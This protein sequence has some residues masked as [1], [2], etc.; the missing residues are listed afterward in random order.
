MFQ[1]IYYSFNT[2]YR[3]NLFVTDADSYVYIVMLKTNLP[4]SLLEAMDR[5]AAETW[6]KVFRALPEEET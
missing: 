3:F 4:R 2:D 6:T 1:C 5:V